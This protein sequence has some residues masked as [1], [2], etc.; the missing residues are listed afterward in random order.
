MK[1][2]NQDKAGG[3]KTRRE[4]MDSDKQLVKNKAVKN[5]KAPSNINKG[6]AGGGAVKNDSIVVTSTSGT[7][8]GMGAAKRGGNYT[9]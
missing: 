2:P 4:K 8:R 6:F 7:C 1:K 9:A 5:S 3:G